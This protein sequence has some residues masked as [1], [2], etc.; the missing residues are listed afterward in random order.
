MNEKF[1]F[2][3]LNSCSDNLQ[4][5]IQNRK[6]V[7]L[8]AI[9]VA[10]TVCGAK[11][12]A[13]QPKKLARI[14]L[15]AGSSLETNRDRVEAFR[16]GLRAHGYVEG[17]DIA[18][19]FRWGAGTGVRLPELAA[20]LVGS[21][22][23]IIVAGGTPAIRAAKN[24]TSVIPIV[25]ANSSDPIA[26]GFVASLAHPGGNITGLSSVSKELSG[27]RL[28]L[29]KETLPKTSRVAVLS[30]PGNPGSVTKL[31]E[32]AV[33]A[34]AFGIALQFLPVQTHDEFETVFGAAARERA[35]GLIVFSDSLFNSHR[36]RVAALA[37]KYR[38]PTM[39]E[40]FEYVRDGG[41]MFYGPSVPD[42]FRRAATYVDKILKGAKPA[43]L[44]VEQPTKFELVIN[45][46]TAKQIGLTIPPNVLARADKVIK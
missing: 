5:K 10:L 7:G 34:K 40:Q 30:N 26:D 35:Y 9:V 45:L 37:V 41:L 16:D 14:G 42:L 38:I 27:K 39:Y 21:Q 22:V 28:E 18:L 32:T 8:F 4:S 44:P 6:W 20:E 2:R 19:E 3:E 23:D 1:S 12:E 25:M 29:I 33:A 31:K 11:T 46:K 36:T 17:K 15:L 43:D 24:A 13:Q